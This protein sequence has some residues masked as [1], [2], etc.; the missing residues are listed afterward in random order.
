M[1]FYSRSGS[2][3]ETIKHKE[4]VKMYAQR[5]GIS[6]EDTTMQIS[7][8]IETIYDGLKECRPITV[9]HFGNFYISEHKE[10]IAFRFNPAQKFKAILGWSSTYRG[11]I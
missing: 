6:E 11:E 4:F 5:A 3:K 9:E 2:K 8:F 7:N 10:S 1:P